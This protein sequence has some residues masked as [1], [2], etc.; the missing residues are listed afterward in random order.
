MVYENPLFSQMVE[1][2][3]KAHRTYLEIAS[4]AKKP[5]D[6]ELPMLQKPMGDKINEIQSFREAGRRCQF[7]N[8]LSAISESIPALGTNF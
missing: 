5:A 8:H 2:A 7:F 3:F 4:Q 6:S 1:A